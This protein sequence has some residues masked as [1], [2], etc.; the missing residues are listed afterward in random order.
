MTGLIVTTFVVN[1]V[2]T[3]QGTEHSGQAIEAAPADEFLPFG[4]ISARRP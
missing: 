2:M 3:R 4:E 1:P